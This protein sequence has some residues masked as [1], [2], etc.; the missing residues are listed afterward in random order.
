[1]DMLVANKRILIVDDN[2]AIHE[3][4]RKILGKRSESQNV[5]DELENSLFDDDEEKGGEPVNSVAVE[6][7]L[8]SAFQG[9]E[10]ME[11]VIKAA[12]EG[13]PY[14]M[15]FVDVR[16]PPGWDGIETVSRIWENHDDLQVVICTAYSDYS[17][18]EIAEK[19]G[20]ADSMVILKKPF[21]N[22]EV[23]QLAHALTNKWEVTQA[24]KAHMLDLDRQVAERT[25]ELEKT[26]AKLTAEIEERSKTQVALQSSEERFSKAF[27]SNP[28]PMAILTLEEQR[29]VDVNEAYLALSGYS[30]NE[31]I[32]QSLSDLELFKDQLVQEKIFDA[33]LS[34]RALRNHSCHLLRKDNEKR[35][36]QIS[37]EI[38]KLGADPHLLLIAQDVTERVNLEGQLR[39][40]QKMEAVGQLAAG[41]AH[42]FNNILTVIRGHIDL[43]MMSDDMDEEVHETLEQVSEA[44]E[45]AASLTRQLLAFSRKQV[46]R[47]K[48][49]QLN[50][51]VKNTYAM[52][53]RLIGEMIDVQLDLKEEL[54]PVFADVCAVEQVV[55]NLSV[56]ARDAMPNGGTLMIGTDSVFVNRSDLRDRHDARSGNFVCLT[57][58]DTG[59]GMS[60]EVQHRIFEPFYTTKKVGKGTGMG[61]ATVYGLVKQHKG[62]IEVESNVDEGTKFTVFLPASTERVDEAPVKLPAR[63]FVSEEKTVLVAEDEKAL[64]RIVAATLQHYGYKTLLAASGAEAIELWKSHSVEIDLLLTDMVM[65]GGVSGKD[66]AEQ[67]TAQ[68][69]GL[70]VIITSGYSPELVSEGIQLAEGVN[71]LPK[72]YSPADLAGI[73][74]KAFASA[75]SPALAG[76]SD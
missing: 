33:L 24:A 18:N 50:D 39:Q 56:N 73:L 45:R 15:A 70:K 61:L 35:S 29:H 55:M 30:R 5:L 68:R 11:M 63:H 3:D 1:M 37:A 67:M 27:K 22:V 71:Y 7:E 49:I 57:V 52:M 31:M 28:M 60:D 72:P 62:W 76:S 48:T 14:A 9:K 34:D 23:L 44:S 51:L 13:R 74:E 17:W 69:P 43:Q 8:D 65:P 64:R 47:R 4:F 21:D 53:T 42:D 36:L 26:N 32:F 66:L 75:G 41:V 20:H 10:G 6:F 38:F 59:E 40:S 25:A 12:E 46:I 16:M 2:P 58:T 54:E 19:L